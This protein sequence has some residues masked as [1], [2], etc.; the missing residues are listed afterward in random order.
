MFK[1]IIL[2]LLISS[3]TSK[4]N[5]KIGQEVQIVSGFYEGCKGVVVREDS[6]SI[7]FKELD[8]SSEGY[9]IYDIWVSKEEL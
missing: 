2:A 8:C 1:Y 9:V 4:K 6:T 3:C 5:Y 7:A